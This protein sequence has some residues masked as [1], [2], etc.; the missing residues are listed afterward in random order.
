M[1]STFRRPT[2]AARSRM[3]AWL[4]AALAL[5]AGA[6]LASCGV[7]PPPYQDPLAGLLNQSS[8]TIPVDAPVTIEQ[9]V[10]AVMSG[11][12]ETYLKYAVHV[13]QDIRDCIGCIKGPALQDVEPKAL[14]ARIVGAIKARFPDVKLVDD[15]N[16]ALRMGAKTVCVIDLQATMGDHSGATTHAEITAIFLNRE[17]RPISRI[18]GHGSFVIPFPST[19]TAHLQEVVADALKELDAKFATLLR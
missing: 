1:A 7:P 11:N 16:E 18:T 9:P 15:L 8:A 4:I 3:K 10:A 17:M 19:L 6:A 2:Q 12:V 14:A 13:Q 5:C